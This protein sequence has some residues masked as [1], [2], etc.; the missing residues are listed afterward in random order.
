MISMDER[1]RQVSRQKAENDQLVRSLAHEGS[2][3]PIS[4]VSLSQDDINQKLADA[5]MSWWETGTSE[6]HAQYISALGMMT[7]RHFDVIHATFIRKHEPL[8]IKEEK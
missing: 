5:Y 2:L 1:V 3:H 6:S 7:A 8:L 4:D